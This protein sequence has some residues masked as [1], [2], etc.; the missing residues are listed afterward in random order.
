MSN[1]KQDI[2]QE[3][4]INTREFPQYIKLIKQKLKYV[5]LFQRKII[6]AMPT[7]FPVEMQILHIL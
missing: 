4:R 1:N 7:L 3:H 6:V 5:K 2:M